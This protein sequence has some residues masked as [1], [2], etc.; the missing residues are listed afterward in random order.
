MLAVCVL[1]YFGAA[2]RADA[3]VRVTF[4]EEGQTQELEGRVVVEAED[5]GIVVC[6]RDGRLWPITPDRLKSREATED[7]F[8]PFSREEMNA[9]LLERFGP[10]FGIVETRHYILCTNT[11]KEYAKWCGKLFERLMGSFQAYWER[12]GVK[13]EEPKLPLVAIVFANEDQFVEFARRDVGPESEGAK[14]YYSIFKNFV[15]LYDL[16]NGAAGGPATTPAEIERRLLTASFNVAAVIHEATHQIAF[17]TGMHQR[18]A[19]N[20]LWLVEGM[21]TFFETPDFNSKT[22]WRTAG[23]LNRL[24]YRGF[25][26]YQEHRRP[27]DSLEALISSHSRFTDPAKL[28]DAYAESWALSY[29]LIRTRR[30]EYLDYLA[31]VA[32]KRPFLWERPEN[33]MED[34]RAA[35]GDD[36]EKLDRDFLRFMERLENK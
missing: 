27:K 12:R 17:N 5:G 28:Q 4:N 29:F 34:F 33:R 24:R 26:D 19:D 36:L 32:K 25:R 23:A 16:S 30:D 22:G 31:R 18:A 7:E 9:R 20:P 11:S 1:L 3:L 21:A 13:L 8:T 14:G 6:G 10:Q 35:F 15:V 2:A